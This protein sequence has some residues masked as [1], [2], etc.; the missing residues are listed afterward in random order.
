MASQYQSQNLGKFGGQNRLKR[1]Q[2]ALFECPM[3]WSPCTSSCP[4]RVRRYHR[5]AACYSIFPV[6]PLPKV[7]HRNR[8]FRAGKLIGGLFCGGSLDQRDF[9]RKHGRPAAS[10]VFS[11]IVHGAACA[12]KLRVCRKKVL[13][14]EDLR[15]IGD[16]RAGGMPV[17]VPKC[18]TCGYQ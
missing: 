17:P 3:H 13:H 18:V 11:T 1:L 5:R 9:S 14:Q 16:C 15:L 2:M 8:I 4:A 12:C 6:C 10:T 7:K